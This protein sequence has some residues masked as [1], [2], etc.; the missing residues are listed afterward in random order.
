MKDIAIYFGGLA[1]LHRSGR[2]LSIQRAVDPYRVADDRAVDDSFQA[3][4]QQV[5]FNVAIDD[6]F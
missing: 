4:C 5:S 6:A 3:D 1:K 2:N